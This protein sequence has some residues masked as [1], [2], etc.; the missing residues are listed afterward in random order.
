MT[1]ELTEKE[2]DDFMIKVD[3][4][5][6]SVEEA[7]ADLPKFKKMRQVSYED[8]VKFQNGQLKLQQE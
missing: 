3:S 8:W 1:K 6:S 4:Y 7:F 5:I 2:Y